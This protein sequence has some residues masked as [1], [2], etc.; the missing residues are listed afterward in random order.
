MRG[1]IYLLFIFLF[2][3]ESFYASK[4]VIKGNAKSFAG[5]EITFIT[6]KDYISNK[7]N[8]LGY[9]NVNNKGSYTY[10]FDINSINK[11]IIKIEDKTTWFFV[12]PGKVYNINI[13]Y[14]ADLNKGRVYDKQLSMFFNF[15]APNELNQLI[16]KFNQKYDQFIDDNT[17]LFKKRD[18]SI[19]PKLKAFKLKMQKE[20]ESANNEFVKNYITYSFASTY[21][22]LD[23][24]YTA[25][26]NKNSNN[27]RANIYLEFLHEKPIL[28]NNSEYMKFFKDF[29][30]GELKS[31]SLELKGV[32]ISRAINDESSYIAL[33]KA[34]SKYPF[35]IDEEFRALFI[36]NSLFSI[37]KDKY[38]TKDN[39]VSILNQIITSTNNSN[40]KEIA[41]NVLFRITEK[42][43]GEG[44]NAPEFE[45]E[46]K[47]GKLYSLENFKGKPIY[48]N[49]WTNWSIPAKKEMKVM[50]VLHKKYKN[51]IHFISICA[52]N[53][54]N[55]MK[56]YLAQ[57]KNQ[58]W[59]F[60]HVG[61]NKKLTDK[62]NVY[63]Y[64]T[65]VLL[66][67][68]L[69]VYKFPAGRPGGTAERATEINIEKDFH[70]LTK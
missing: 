61:G 22:S 21:H 20:F 38:F 32:D 60:L 24:G 25:K 11:V 13:S 4:T 53:D 18:R 5:N 63:T 47:D 27:T 56:N 31:L 6:Y 12:E 70:E 62:Y 67:K 2:I 48:I 19:E 3:S 41:Q 17:L 42:R 55:K 45:L 58:N 40:L 16:K 28:Y 51:K 23:V 35:L 8:E 26:A 43:F 50:E 36:I 7:K 39:I 1:S 59:V 14:D 64:P 65:Y 33:S 49:F 69:K 29:F 10:E 54:I 66:D 46:D 37:S 44:S 34:L 15:P 9:C 52:D 68:N 57:N 30:K